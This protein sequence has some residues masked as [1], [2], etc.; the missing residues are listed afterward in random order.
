VVG[1]GER[2]RAWR[3]DEVEGMKWR[4]RWDEV[5]RSIEEPMMV[6][7]VGKE[8]QRKEGGRKEEGG[9]EEGEE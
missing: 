2:E 8:E 5:G 9:M 1:G 6:L 4:R 7:T 3:G